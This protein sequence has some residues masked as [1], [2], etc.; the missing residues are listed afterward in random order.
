MDHAKKLEFVKHMTKLGLQHF[1]A[2]GTVLGGPSA[3]GASSGTTTGGGFLGGIGATLGLNNNF[4]AGAANIQ[5]GTNQAQLNQAY[6]GTQSSLTGA[7]NLSNTLTP[8]AQQAANQ[9]AALAQQ[10]SMQASGQGPN[11]AQNQLNQATGQNVAN[12]AAL[13]AGQRGAS[14]NVGLLARQAAQQGADTQQ[15]AAGQ[16]ATLGAQQQIAAQQQLASL[17]GQ[18][19]SQTGQAIANQSSAQQAEQNILQQANTAAN[20]AAVGMQSNMNNVN[21]Q[22]AAANQNMGSKIL[23]GVTSMLSNVPV[24]G[25][26]FGA[27]GGQ[28]DDG[29]FVAPSSE[30]SSGP[31][32]PATAS[33]PADNSGPIFGGSK[34]GG[35]GGGGAGLLAM[36]ARGGSISAN[37]LIA[38]PAAHGQPQSFI[39]QWLAGSQASAGSGPNIPATSALPVDNSPLVKDRSEDEPEDEGTT[40]AG[41]YSGGSSLTGSLTG[42][43][44]AGASQGAPTLGET[45]L[46]AKGGLMESGGK[47]KAN[48]P[49][50][51]AVKKGDSY[52]ND[53]VPALLSE[54]EVVIPRHVMQSNDPAGNAAK[55]VQA[56]IAKKGFKRGLK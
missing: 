10:L 54:G 32:I 55:F 24:V 51:K 48:N 23:G 1:D 30:N 46:S 16:A 45:R 20:N 29:K 42:M 25:S 15:Q 43:Q 36:L 3:A 38:A 39:G 2:G 35:G 27:E 5:Q 4:Q 21:S 8:Q 12:Q 18:Q 44:S 31:S 50:Q 6:Q 17:S 11:P 34:S 28:V 22:T 14:S 56:I 41:T 13:M 52:D 19:I 33:L 49:K 7:D 9:Q 40:N 37:P 53:K 26:L 47:V